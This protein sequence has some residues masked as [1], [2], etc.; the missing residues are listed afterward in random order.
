[1]PSCG[2]GSKD[3][4]TIKLKDWHPATG[5]NVDSTNDPNVNKVDPALPDSPAI[6]FRRSSLTWRRI[7][8]VR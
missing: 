2:R 6:K 7:L 1:M 8:Q 4:D 5:G 3:P